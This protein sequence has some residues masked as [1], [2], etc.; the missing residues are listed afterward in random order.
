[1]AD[2]YRNERYKFDSKDLEEA[3]FKRH[4]LR[5]QAVQER[6]A[7]EHFG[8]EKKRVFHV[9]MHACLLGTLTLRA[10]RPREVRH[11]LFADTGAQR[12][13]VLARYSNGVGIE[14][15]DV[16]PDVRGSPETL[17]RQCHS[18]IHVGRRERVFGA[19][20]EGG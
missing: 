18:E 15:H 6:L 20:G 7:R 4:V 2:L 14:A 9:K 12:Y 5:V 8:G 1:M 10:D 17:K 16:K 3:E 11:G 19:S 13:N